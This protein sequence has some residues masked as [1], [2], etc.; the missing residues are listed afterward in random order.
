MKIQYFT[1]LVGISIFSFA[2]IAQAEVEA[3]AGAQIMWCFSGAVLSKTALTVLAHQRGKNLNGPAEVMVMGAG[4][5]GA[6]STVRSLTSAEAPEQEQLNKE[7]TT[8][9]TNE[10]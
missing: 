6:V 2:G 8:D 10:E 9:Q 1:L 3:S 7:E 4:C 5:A